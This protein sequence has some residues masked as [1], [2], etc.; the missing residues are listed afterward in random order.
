MKQELV[1]SK[2]PLQ[3]V[4]RALQVLLSYCDRKTDWG[5]LELA[6]EFGLDKSSAQRILAALAARRFLHNDPITRRYSLGPAMWRMATV[7]E[8]TGGFSRLARPV[9][10]PLAVSTNRTALF[11][12]PDGL[13]VRCVA[14]VDGASPDRNHPMLGDLFP[15]NSGATARGYFAFIDSAERRSLLSGRI[16]AQFTTMT[17]SDEKALETLF[18][19]A[20]A[21]GYALSEGEYDS[22]TRA[23][24]LPIRLR[25]RPVG[26][27][28]LVEQKFPPA[29]DALLDLLPRLQRAS[30][31][32]S[33]LLDDRRMRG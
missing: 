14:A 9:L 32:L 31:E 17:A 30:D 4:D 10:E 7:W 16:L 28:S 29:P 25:G 21:Q 8:R 5:V 3:T 15:I 23:L 24:G 19:Q 6:E 1:P 33:A 20:Q 13:H 12:I 27:I 18:M 22:D 26:S 11:A 2:S